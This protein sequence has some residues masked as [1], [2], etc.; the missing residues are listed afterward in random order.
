MPCASTGTFGLGI[1][2]NLINR[3]PVELHIPGY[4]FCGPGTRLKQRL[5][6]GQRGVNPLDAA[7]RE[8]DIAY[9][10]NQHDISARHVADRILQKKAWERT[11]APDSSLGEKAA[12]F[13]VANIM[14]VKRRFG[15]GMKRKHRKGVGK[16]RGP[17]RRATSSRT[18]KNRIG[19]GLGRRQGKKKKRGKTGKTVAK[20]NFAS[21]YRQLCAKRSKSSR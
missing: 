21:K 4:Q 6:Q 8:H 17:K 18:R 5:A 20:K 15:L 2:N 7:C 19:R 13:A 11:L 14:K 9:S 12:A 3:L 10:E 16:K 1:V